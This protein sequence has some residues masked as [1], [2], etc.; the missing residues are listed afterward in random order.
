MLMV[1]LELLVVAAILYGIVKGV[2]PMAAALA[3]GISMAV[4]T[5]RGLTDSL[6]KG[7]RGIQQTA[8][9]GLALGKGAYGLGKGAYGLGKAGMNKL[10]GNSVSNAGGGGWQPAY[11]AATLGNLQ[12]KSQ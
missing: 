12:R 11:N 3:G 4:M 9:A 8:K 2:M 5:A 1:A 6:D 7:R 10:R